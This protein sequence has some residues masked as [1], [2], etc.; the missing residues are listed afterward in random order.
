ML[1]IKFFIFVLMGALGGATERYTQD[2]PPPETGWKSAVKY[3][4]KTGSVK[5]KAQQNEVSLEE[6]DAS[7][8][9]VLFLDN[10]VY[11]DNRQGSSL[12]Q[13]GQWAMK[14]GFEWDKDWFSKGFYIQ[15]SDY[16]EERKFSLLGGLI[17]PSLAS[18]FP[19]YLKANVGLGYFVGDFDNQTLAVE[20]NAQTGLRF[21]A[22]NGMLFNI[23]VG[24]VNYTRLLTHS[25]LNSVTLSSG[26]AYRF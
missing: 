12:D 20:Y 2:E 13:P 11:V 14:L 18:K 23:E 1:V 19:V 8:G 17:F 4:G 15:H 9:R 26:L 22:R 16:D 24:T 10:L 21:F 25:Y 7:Y 5:S 6:S 3:F